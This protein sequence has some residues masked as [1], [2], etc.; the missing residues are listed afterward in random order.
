[1]MRISAVDAVA[2]RHCAHGSFTLFDYP[3]VAKIEVN[4]DPVHPSWVSRYAAI[5]EV[6][7]QEVDVGRRQIAKLS[8]LG[9]ECPRPDRQ[10]AVHPST[11]G[12]P[13]QTRPTCD[14]RRTEAAGLKPEHRGDF[15]STSHTN[16]CSHAARTLEARRGSVD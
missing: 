8:C 1:M 10:V 12:R 14:G 9:A 11:H 7:A 6:Q 4:L 3:E 5:A 13:R 16:T 2:R 15:A